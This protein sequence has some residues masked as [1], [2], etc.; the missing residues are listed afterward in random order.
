MKQEELLAQL[1]NF[2]RPTLRLFLSVDIVGSTAFKQSSKSPSAVT[3][4]GAPWLEATTLFYNEFERLFTTAWDASTSELKAK[5]SW[6][7][8]PSPDLWK[9]AGDELIYTKALT[10]HRQAFVAVQAWTTAVK[11]FKPALKKFSRSL[12]LKCT[13]WLAGFPVTN[14]EVMLRQSLSEQDK[15]QLPDDDSLVSNFKLLEQ[16]GDRASSLVKDYIGPS[17][18][19]GFRLAA[20]STPRKFVLSLDLALLLAH[21]LVTPPDTEFQVT[22]K[23]R[24]DGK[25]TL[26]GVLEGVPYPIFWIDV[27]PDDKLNKA[28]DRLTGQDSISV[29]DMR[30]FCQ[31]F[32]SEMEDKMFRPYIIGNPDSFFT[33]V[34]DSHLERLKTYFDYWQNEKEK[35]RVEQDTSEPVAEVKPGARATLDLSKFVQLL[36][37]ATRQNKPPS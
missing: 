19:T 9:A 12:D 8:G 4:L 36:A 34:P 1:P 11:G 13:A 16:L 26:K 23:F 20:L 17:I 25:E 22:T 32:L 5:Y 21:T 10:D 6:Q 29:S 33:I 31:V 3:K 35:R 7:M 28:E 27:D 18:D 37:E 2:L 15:L 30:E 14:A 24:F